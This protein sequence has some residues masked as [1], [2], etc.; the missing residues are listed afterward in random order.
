MTIFVSDLKKEIH[1][2]VY[3]VLGN[4]PVHT[5]NFLPSNNSPRDGNIEESYV[6]INSMTIVA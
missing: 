2:D 5:I 6:L 4:S 3:D 1:Q